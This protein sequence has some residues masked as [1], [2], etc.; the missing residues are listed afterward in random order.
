MDCKNCGAKN[1]NDSAFCSACGV[2]LQEINPSEPESMEEGRFE[3]YHTIR[4][5]QP[6]S[7][8]T[9][10]WY[11]RKP[12]GRACGP[13]SYDDV[14]DDYVHHD[15]DDSYQVRPTDSKVWT[16]ILSSEFFVEK[17]AV[18]RSNIIFPDWF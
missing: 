15:I 11:Y 12:G 3:E 2:A 17:P 8:K 9:V 1:E 18:A 4:W 7:P 14:M 16:P 6:R 5:E 13:F 10:E